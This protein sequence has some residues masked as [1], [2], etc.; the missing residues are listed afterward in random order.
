MA[1]KEYSQR[2]RRYV[3]EY[4]NERFPDREFAVYNEAIGLPPEALTKAHPE[5]PIEYF[6]KS[7]HYPDAIVGWHGLLILIETKIRYPRKG[8]ADL[9]QYALEIHQTPQLAAYVN[10]PLQMRLVI[11]REDPRIIQLASMQNIVV[12]IFY[13]PWVG[14]YLREIGMM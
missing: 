14:D 13:K 6:Q 5:L 7:R 1:R 10:R 9:L 8:I 4:V 2:E 11:P 12:D 3:Q